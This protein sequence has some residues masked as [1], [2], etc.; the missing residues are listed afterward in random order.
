M[1][2]MMISGEQIIDNIKIYN[3]FIVLLSEF[4][5]NIFIVLL[6]DYFHIRII[7]YDY[8]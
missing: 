1:S 6:S 7:F 8:K 3:I 2:D 4:I 5:Y